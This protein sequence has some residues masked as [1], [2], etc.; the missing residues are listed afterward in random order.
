MLFL[1]FHCVSFNNECGNCQ[2]NL[3]KYSIG[4]ILLVEETEIHGHL[5]KMALLYKDL[6]YIFL[7][8]GID[9]CDGFQ[10]SW[11]WVL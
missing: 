10:F 2:S 7:V 9:R 8:S 3:V 5:N 11:A 4:I 6:W 1:V